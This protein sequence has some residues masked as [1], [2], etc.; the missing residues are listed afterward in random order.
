LETIEGVDQQQIATPN[1]VMSSSRRRSSKA[2]VSLS[3]AIVDR[4]VGPF[5]D[6]FKR[7][8]GGM[9][10]SLFVKPFT[11]I[12]LAPE[13][14]PA[15]LGKQY[16]PAKRELTLFV[17][18][19]GT[20]TADH[21]KAIDDAARKG[22]ERELRRE[23]APYTSLL[24]EDGALKVA[25]ND[26]TTLVLCAADGDGSPAGTK[27]TLDDLLAD[28]APLRSGGL[29]AY[30]KLTA[31]TAWVKGNAAGCKA[32]ALK[33]AF[34]QTAGADDGDDSD[35]YLLASSAAKRQRLA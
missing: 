1:L 22:A 32:R 35:G 19:D 10:Q 30:I 28:D 29:C 27:L 31:P 15:Q 5:K 14:L 34:E 18:V 8:M 21:I 23:A 24:T 9:L 3:P 2:V 17:D 4:V 12:R 20:P 13:Y 6:E 25:L 33:V 16:D 11:V 7:G 26:K